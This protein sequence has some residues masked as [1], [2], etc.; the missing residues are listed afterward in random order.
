[1]LDPEGDALLHNTFRHNGYFGNPSNSDYGQI[2]LSGGEP[3]NC[4]AGNKAPDGS[5]PSNL[6]KTQPKC[7]AKTKAARPGG[8]LLTQVLCD[9]G[10]APC[11]SGAHYPKPNGKVVLTPLPHGLPTMPN[12]CAGVPG[13][14]VV[15]APGSGRAQ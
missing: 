2:T 5:A 6:E 12:P 7:G 11:P 10:L 1:M 8:N 4:F 15:P 3:Q 9:T 13:Q 14:P